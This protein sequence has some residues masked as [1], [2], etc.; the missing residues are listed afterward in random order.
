MGFQ[1]IPFQIRYS[2][3][4]LYRSFGH[5]TK[6]NFVFDCFLFF[7]CLDLDMKNDQQRA[8]LMTSPTKVLHETN[9]GNFLHIFMDELNALDNID[10]NHSIH[11][12]LS[13]LDFIGKSKLVMISFEI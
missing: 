5:Y 9:F 11:I 3:P 4:A 10:F 12:Y 6:H 7:I 1:A 2:K 13:D 8:S